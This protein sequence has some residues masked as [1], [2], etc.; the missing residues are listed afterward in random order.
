[1][2][3]LNPTKRS[4]SQQYMLRG[5]YYK[6]FFKASL[7][8]VRYSHRDCWNMILYGVFPSNYIYFPWRCCIGDVLMDVILSPLMF[9][10]CPVL[11]P[12]CGL[13]VI[14][15][16]R[17]LNSIYIGVFRYASISCIQMPNSLQWVSQFF[18]R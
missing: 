10:R 3:Q 5:A 12:L 17:T 15:S 9:S 18:T 8:R 11:G 1:M 2:T 16:W 6:M 7:L 14:G 4:M 13:G